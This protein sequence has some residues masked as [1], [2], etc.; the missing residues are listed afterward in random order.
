MGSKKI[1]R[2]LP[3]I[4]RPMDIFVIAAERKVRETVRVLTSFKK[5]VEC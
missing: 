4:R 5:R 1:M 3:V 2:Q